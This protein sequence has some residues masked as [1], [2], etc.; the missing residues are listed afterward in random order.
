MSA[1]TIFWLLLALLVVFI[2]A[3]GVRIVQQSEA[4]VI[5]RLGRYQK[6]LMAGFNIIIPI[7]DKPREI[8]FRFTRDLPDGNKYVQFVKK[9]RI[10]MRETVYDFPRQNVIT[11]D[12]VM[13][14]INALLYFQVMDPV[15]A[16]YEIENLP[17]A[18]EKLTQTTLRNVIGELD[19]DECLTSR[20][21]INMKLRTILDEASHK[22]GVKV[23]R[24]ELQDIN[25]PRD[26]REAMEKQMRAER[27]RRAQIIDAEGSKRAAV[28][29]A[30][31]IQQAQITQAEGQKQSQ[32]LEAEGDAQARIRRAQG[33][34][35]AISLVTRAVAGS[36]AD[37]TTYL[38]A[39][40]YLETLKEMTSGQ[41][42]K[43][44]YIPYEASGVLSSVGS[45]KEMLEANRTLGQ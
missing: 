29:Q 42:N 33:E 24:V 11:K 6:T 34:A 22:W 9:E 40:K 20:D 38:I 1:V 17:L 45:I 25:P 31:G 8:I 5:E 13:T 16:I 14:E 23:N 4:M 44:I 35:E 10:D 32:V 15:K 30:E 27:D 12:N 7:L 21:T 43:V 37:P 26:I 28:L 18:I 36:K 39:M 3:K 41:G 19:L 2:I